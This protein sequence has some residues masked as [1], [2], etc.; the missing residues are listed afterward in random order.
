MLIKIV[1]VTLGALA[2]KIGP[3]RKICLS[4][5]LTEKALKTIKYS[6]SPEVGLGFTCSAQ[7][8]P[9]VL[10]DRIGYSVVSWSAKHLKSVISLDPPA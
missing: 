6:S 9:I 2:P 1:N 7:V 5:A 8:V 10:G 4:G 3:P